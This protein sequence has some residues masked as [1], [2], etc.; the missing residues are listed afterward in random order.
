MSRQNQLLEEKV[1]E[2]T[3]ELAEANQELTVINE[4]L[5]STLETV[6]IQTETIRDKNKDITA[7][8]N[9]AKRIQKASM[10][11]PTKMADLFNEFFVFHR[12]RDIVSG[13]FFW[14]V[15]VG[16]KTLVA[17]VDC[18]GHG[19]PGAFMS[20]IGSQNLNEITKTK[21]ITA[22]DEILAELQK[23]IAVNL[24]QN[25]N[26]NQDGMDMAL[27]CIDMDTK[28]L[29]FAGAKNPLTYIDEKGELQTIKGSRASIGGQV[30]DTDT[31][32]FERHDIQLKE[33]MQF[34]LYSDGYQD[35]FGGPDGKKFMSRRLREHLYSHR[36]NSLEKQGEL[37]EETFDNWRGRERQIDDV[38][39]IG[40]KVF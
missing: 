13:D 14:T 24:D 17:V 27:C 37:L 33:G 29:S 39:V 21:G 36:K 19:V 12:P 23:A 9:Y 4:E 30:E 25:N 26:Q 40:I 31:N 20:M 15:T 2:R 7:S 34:Y 5:N 32:P 38:M 11:S 10:P 3:F 28:T 18:T 35:Q 16:N 6:S 8:I 1:Q 22:P